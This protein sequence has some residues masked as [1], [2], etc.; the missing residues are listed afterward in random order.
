MYSTNKA[1]HSSSF[2]ND[3]NDKVD[4][5][6]LIWLFL[7]SSESRFGRG[8][9]TIHAFFTTMFVGGVDELFHEMQNRFPELGLIKKDCNKMSWISLIEFD[10]YSIYK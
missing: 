6:R 8:Q 9:K 1:Y 10:I 4:E 3:Y 5:N 2:I 7:R